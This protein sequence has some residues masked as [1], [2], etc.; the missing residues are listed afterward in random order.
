[1]LLFLI[2]VDCSG[3]LCSFPVLLCSVLLVLSSV[4]LWLCT[5]PSRLLQSALFMIASALG[6]LCVIGSLPLLDHCVVCR[7]DLLQRTRLRGKLLLRESSVPS[8]RSVFLQ[9]IT[10]WP[11]SSC[12]RPGVSG[13]DITSSSSTSAHALL[14]LCS[15]N[16]PVRSLDVL[17]TGRLSSRGSPLGPHQADGL[18]TLDLW[19]VSS[20]L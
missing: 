6:S 8:D 19:M 17:L 14:F 4:A 15:E 3:V 12:G 2:R 10:A 16:A 7:L 13:P 9:R 20:G 5:A 1:M 18:M 11:S